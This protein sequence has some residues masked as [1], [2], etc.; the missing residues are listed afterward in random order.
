MRFYNYEFS[1][2]FYEKEEIRLKREEKIQIFKSCIIEC[3]INS[4]RK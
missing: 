4:E 1:E 2:D 3:L